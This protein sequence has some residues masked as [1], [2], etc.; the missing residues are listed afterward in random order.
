MGLSVEAVF[1]LRDFY[2]SNSCF[3]C[4]NLELLL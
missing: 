4:S 3:V 2:H 1:W